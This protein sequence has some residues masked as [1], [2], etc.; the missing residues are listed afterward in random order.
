MLSG[1][2]YR[3]RSLPDVGVF[4]DMAMLP[5]S[6]KRCN[7]IPTFATTTHIPHPIHAECR[8]HEHVS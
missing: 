1:M 4:L 3:I 2:A 8:I 6:G 5:V 7:K